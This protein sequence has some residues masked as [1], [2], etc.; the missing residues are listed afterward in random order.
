MDLDDEWGLGRRPAPQLYEPGRD[1]LE[2]SVDVLDATLRG[3]QTYASRNLEGCC[4]WY[5]IVKEENCSQV[6]AVVVPRQ[7]NSWGNYQVS[8]SEMARVSAATRYLGIRNLAQ[9]H[10]HPSAL[11]EHSSYDDEMA[12]SRRALSLVLPNY[13]K[14]RVVWPIGV[15]VHEFQNDYWHRLSDDQARQRVA[16]VGSTSSVELIDLRLAR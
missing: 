7:R 9:L 11:V 1:M 2:I 8:S 14:E 16:L 15:G 13:G 6:T 4:F 3:I 12:N 10:T 5:G